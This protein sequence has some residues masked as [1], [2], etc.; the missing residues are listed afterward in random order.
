M[1]R[2]ERN[3]AWIEAHC[4]VPEGRLVGKPVKLTKE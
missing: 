1:T 2:A 4:K 3:A